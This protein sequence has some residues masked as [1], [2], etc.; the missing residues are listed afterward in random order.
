MLPL[1]C[2]ENVIFLA[3]CLY[4]SLQIQGN[5]GWEIDIQIIILGVKHSF[6][7]YN[8]SRYWIKTRETNWGEKKKLPGPS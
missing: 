4:M 2:K 8:K 7:F 6:K 1:I 5:T 3:F